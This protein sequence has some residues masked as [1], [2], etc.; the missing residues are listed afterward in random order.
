MGAVECLEMK[1]DEGKAFKIHCMRERD[2]VMK[3]MASWVK[4]NNL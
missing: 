2:Y 3:L 1:S 4:L